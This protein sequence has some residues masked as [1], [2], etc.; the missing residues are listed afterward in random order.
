MDPIDAALAAIES[1]RPGEDFTYSDI[2]RRFG[3]VRSTLTRR[4]QRA[5]LARNTTDQDQRNL[6]QH[7]EREL[8]R[9]I[10]RLTE[11]GLPPT[12]QMIQNFASCI[13]KKD[14]SL[15]WTD[16]FVKRH[17]EDLIMS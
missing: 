7:Q 13:A 3:V 15:S 2:A 16:R 12:Q 8:I 14:V 17:Q 4:H 9:Y 6:S 1:L 10:T 11:R 5:S